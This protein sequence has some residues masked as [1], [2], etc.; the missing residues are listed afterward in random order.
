MNSGV[1]LRCTFFV[2]FFCFSCRFTLSL[3][4]QPPP[5][6]ATLLQLRQPSHP[7]GEEWWLYGEREKEWTWKRNWSGEKDREHLFWLT[8][9]TTTKVFP[10]IQRP[11]SG[12]HLHPYVQPRPHRFESEYGDKSAAYLQPWAFPS[13]QHHKQPAEE[14][15]GGGQRGGDG[16]GGG[17][18][19]SEQESQIHK[20]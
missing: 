8:D 20:W 5:C 6:L 12:K 19:K 7:Q 14:R 13:E 17:D 15:E 4:S 18:G 11:V 10:P 1:K 9:R 16:G 3:P 2:C